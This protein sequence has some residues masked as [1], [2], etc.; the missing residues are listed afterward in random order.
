MHFIEVCFIEVCGIE[1]FFYRGVCNKG[2]LLVNEQSSLVLRQYILPAFNHFEA[3]I[4]FNKCNHFFKYQRHKQ[5]RVL[6]K[7]HKSIQSVFV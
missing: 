5:P 7:R 4:A 2:V 6:I 3:H 1:V